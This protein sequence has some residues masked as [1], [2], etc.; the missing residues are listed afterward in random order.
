MTGVV[1]PGRRARGGRARRRCGAA[2]TGG[3]RWSAAS[4]RHE[5]Q[6][7]SQSAGEWT[8]SGSAVQS[9]PH[10]ERGSSP[11]C[12]AGDHCWRADRRRDGVVVA[13]DEST[14]PRRHRL[15]SDSVSTVGAVSRCRGRETA[16]TRQD[17]EVEA[18]GPQRAHER[19]RASVAGDHG[20]A[21]RFGAAGSRLGQQHGARAVGT[22]RV[23]RFPSSLVGRAVAVGGVDRRRSAAAACLR[24]TRPVAWTHT[25]PG[26]R[27]NTG[28]PAARSRRRPAWRPRTGCSPARPPPG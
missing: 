11:D 20:D 21:G 16:A 9:G 25:P 18:A 1:L 7:V 6:L 15:R 28:A 12:P 3:A 10:A 23:A 17:R 27:S 4:R 19:G 14:G 5:V 8:M 2:R 22:R 13:A 24:I 26:G